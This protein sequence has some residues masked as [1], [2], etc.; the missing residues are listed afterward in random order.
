MVPL[1]I[2]SPRLQTLHCLGDS[3]GLSIAIGAIFA[4]CGGSHFNGVLFI[5]SLY[6]LFQCNGIAVFLSKQKKK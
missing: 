4:N 6:I 5:F 3:C 1:S 2:P